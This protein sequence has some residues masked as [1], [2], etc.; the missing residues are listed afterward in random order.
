MTDDNL[1]SPYLELYFTKNEVRQKN[2]HTPASKNPVK[3]LNQ[4]INKGVLDVHETR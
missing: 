3:K 4:Q 1:P 2:I